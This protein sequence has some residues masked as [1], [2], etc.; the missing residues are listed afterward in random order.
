MVESAQK[1]SLSEFLNWE[2]AQDMRHEFYRGQG[3]KIDDERVVNA[4]VVGNLAAALHGHTKG[5]GC[6]T[7]VVEVFRRNER[8]NFE[9]HD[10]T[11]HAELVLDSVG[12]RLTMD[13][14]FDGIETETETETDAA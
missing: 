12:L 11:G 14:L 2:N 9:L 10:Q 13:E 8:Q 7:F 1:L 3:L 5:Q 6:R 4:F